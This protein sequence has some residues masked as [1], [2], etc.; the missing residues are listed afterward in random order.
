MYNRLYEKTREE[1]FIWND[2]LALVGGI[3]S[4][5]RL[6]NRKAVV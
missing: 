6:Y 5:L 1:A 2:G 4:K 3:I